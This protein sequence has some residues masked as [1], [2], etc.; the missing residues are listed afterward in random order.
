MVVVGG[1]AGKAFAPRSWETNAE[2]LPLFDGGEYAKARTLLSAALARYDDHATLHYNLACAEA[3]L[4]E[5]DSALQHLAAALRERPSLAADAHADSDL[6][7]IRGDPRF[8]VL[9]PEVPGD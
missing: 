9:V 4:G 8:A 5:P 7:P 2:V 1:A 6:D 3:R